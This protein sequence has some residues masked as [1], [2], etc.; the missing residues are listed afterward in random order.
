MNFKSKPRRLL[1]IGCILLIVVV[2]V[3]ATMA[4]NGSHGAT[5][6]VSPGKSPSPATVVCIGFVDVNPG[7]SS[8]HPAQVGRVVEVA[9]EGK[10]VA[11]GEVLLRLESE[12]PKLNVKQAEIDLRNAQE[13]FK[14][15]QTLPQQQEQKIMQQQAK[16]ASVKYEKLSVAADLEVKKD[17][18]R[19]GGIQL[20]PKIL[21]SLEEKLKEYDESLKAETSKLEELKLYT[22]QIDIN[23][24]QNDVDA[25]QIQLELAH[26]ALQQYSLVAPSDGTVLRVNV[27]VGEVLGANPQAPAMQFCPAGPK[28][29]RAEVQQ[30]WAPFVRLG[31]QVTLVDDS[32]SAEKWQGKLARL[33]E[34]YAKRRTIIL[35]PL[36][37]NDVR[38]LEAIV[39]LT[40]NDKALRIGQRVLVQITDSK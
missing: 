40:S 3:G 22:P 28:I 23:R 25:K 21:Q 20:S 13:Q 32:S 4:V 1:W 12:L 2:A 19:S 39:E 15:A 17:S 31:Q 33:S 7:V 10:T 18:A 34:W 27:N 8:L 5:E 9:T 26:Y 16:I 24:A 38:T 6:P 30:E 11:K 14:K 37:V 35:E 29:V 36:M